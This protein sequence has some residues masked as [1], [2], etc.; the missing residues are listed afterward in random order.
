MDICAT[1]VKNNLEVSQKMKKKKK[2]TSTWFSS[3]TPGYIFGK[4]KTLSKGYVH[5]SVHSD[6][7]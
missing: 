1:T 6:S 5:P 2:T 3:P 4:T 7:I